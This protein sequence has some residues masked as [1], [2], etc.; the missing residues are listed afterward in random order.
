MPRC[1]FGASEFSDGRVAAW[2]GPRVNRSFVIAFRGDD[3]GL[4]FAAKVVA[5]FSARNLGFFEL[6]FWSERG[7]GRFISIY[8]LSYHCD[9]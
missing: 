3:D 1:G 8:N 9:I 5:A 4:P 6:G 2:E 7:N